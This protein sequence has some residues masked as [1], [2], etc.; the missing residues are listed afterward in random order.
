MKTAIYGAGSLGTVLG[1]YLGK[2]G[3]QVELVNRNRA[4]VDALNSSGARVIGETEMTV[5]VHAV[6]PEEMKGPYDVIILMTKQSDNKSVARFLRP[7]LA[8][9]GVLCTAQN[10]LPEPQ[11]AGILGEDRVVGCAVLW[12]ATLEEPGTARLTSNPGQMSFQIGSLNGS[13]ERQLLLVKTLLEHMCPVTIESNFIGARFSK[14]LLNSAFSG[15]STITGLRFGE[16]SADRKMRAVTQRVIKENIDVA[17]A[18]KIELAPVQGKDI[19]KLMDYRGPIKRKLANWIIPLAIKGHVN[20]RSGMI[21][22]IERGRKTDIDEINGVVCEYGRRYGVETS[23]N[24]RIVEIV[25]EIEDGVLRPEPTNID[26]F[27]ELM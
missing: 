26:L 24:S 16:I 22:D 19:A 2:A 20:I 8:E 11:L 25:H 7:L 5:K 14:L 4:Q 23:F 18:A 15:L 6:V 27:D 10:G 1:A 9:D 13:N 12:G 17:R 3:V 21:G